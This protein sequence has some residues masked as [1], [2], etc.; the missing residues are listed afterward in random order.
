MSIRSRTVKYTLVYSPHAIWCCMMGCRGQLKGRNI[1]RMRLYYSSLR[2]AWL[3]P[4]HLQGM[5]ISGFQTVADGNLFVSVDA[6][7]VHR[8]DNQKVQAQLHTSSELTCVHPSLL[9]SD[10]MVWLCNLPL[11]SKPWMM[12]AAEEVSSGLS[13]DTFSRAEL[14]WDNHERA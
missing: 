7:R 1:K 3:W 6:V 11:R 5:G 12:Y 4:H 8:Q 13:R 10:I 14:A 9:H 2:F